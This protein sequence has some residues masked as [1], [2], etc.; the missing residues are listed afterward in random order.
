MIDAAAPREPF[1][2]LGI[3]QGGAICI[4]YAVRH[5]ERVS[6]LVLYGGYARA[7]RAAATPRRSASTG[8]SAT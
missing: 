6:R 8:P 7:G 5:P 1:A 2:M 3:S 4:A